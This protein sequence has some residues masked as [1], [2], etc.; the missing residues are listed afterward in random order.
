MNWP[1]GNNFHL[2]VMETAVCTDDDTIDQH[3]PG[4]AP[5]DTHTGSGTGKLNGVLGASAEW[6][7]VDGGEPGT[8][9]FWSLTVR[10]ENDVIVLS[11]TNRPLTLGNH[12]TH[13][14]N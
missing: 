1:E 11:F 14:T 7:I 8:N 9:D 3:P 5:F 4:S 12:Q 2:E 6:V 10:D 13:K